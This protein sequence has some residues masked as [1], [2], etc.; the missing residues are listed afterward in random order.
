MDRHVELLRNLFLTHPAWL[1]AA[2]YIKDRSNSSVRFSHVPG[3]YHLL[4]KDGQLFNWRSWGFGLKKLFG[5]RN[6]FF[7]RLLGP[8]LDYY[9]PGFHPRDHDTDTLENRWRERLGF[10]S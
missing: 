3:A 2:R 4:R 7:T 8:Y 10:S 6:G 1:A 9:R 5:P